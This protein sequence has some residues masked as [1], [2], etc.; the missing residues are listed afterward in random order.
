[1]CVLTDF[2]RP[3]FEPRFSRIA[4]LPGEGEGSLPALGDRAFATNDAAIKA[5]VRTFVVD[6]DV[7]LILQGKLTLPV[8]GADALG[9]SRLGYDKPAI[10]QRVAIENMIF[11]DP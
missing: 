9:L 11:D 4:V 5:G 8:Q 7:R 1:M 2:E 6:D 10:E 3:A